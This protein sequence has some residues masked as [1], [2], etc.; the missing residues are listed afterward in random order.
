MIPI[1]VDARRDGETCFT[2]TLSGGRL[3]I[4]MDK[5][6]VGRPRPNPGY[7]SSPILFAHHRRKNS[8]NG[9]VG[10]RYSEGTYIFDGLVHGVRM[11]RVLPFSKKI[12]QH[13]ILD[14]I[15]VFVTDGDI[16][17]IYGNEFVVRHGFEENIYL[18]RCD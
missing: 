7:V 1:V 3:Y 4:N 5:L 14:N 12:L 10:Y 8:N 15:A 9:V 17:N 13:Q 6:L 18:E 16:I 11:I 2:K